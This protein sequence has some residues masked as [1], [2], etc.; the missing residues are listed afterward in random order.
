LGGSGTTVN[1]ATH[2]VVATAGQTVFP[3]PHTPITSIAWSFR[4]GARLP[5]AA[6]IVSGS[7][8]TYIPSAN[9]NN[10]LFAGDRI[11][12]DYIY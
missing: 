6:M 5:K 7:T 12:F 10:I 11:Q 2:E 4:N 9:N 8:A 3:L 1:S